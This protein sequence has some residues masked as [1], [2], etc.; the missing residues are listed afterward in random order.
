M[1]KVTILYG[2]PTDP[3]AFDDYYRNVHVPIAAKMKG[4]TAWT[5]TW[6]SEQNGEEMPPVHL[7]AEL[8]AADREA[9]MAILESPEGQTAR[10]D[11]ENFVTGGVT[12]LYGDEEKVAVL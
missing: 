2:T 4:L 9:M 3:A 5:L 12:F 6:V 10:D 1:Y 7:I 8:Y 11:L